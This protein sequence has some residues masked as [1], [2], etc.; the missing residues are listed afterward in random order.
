MELDIYCAKTSTT[1]TTAQIA[2]LKSGTDKKTGLAY[3][4][5]EMI[6]PDEYYTVPDHFKVSNTQCDILKLEIV[7][8]TSGNMTDV[9]D[10]TGTF[11]PIIVS[12]ITDKFIKIK[13]PPITIFEKIFRFRVRA[14][15]DGGL[16]SYTADI[17]IKKVNCDV[18]D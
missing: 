14:T 4:Y 3:D 18:P 12:R 11:P 5:Y 13:L 10:N 6:N 1:F 16:Q 8:V 2:P 9:L 7:E 15:A 17:K